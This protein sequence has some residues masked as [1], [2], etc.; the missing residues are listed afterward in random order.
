[1]ECDYIKNAIPGKIPKEAAKDESPE[2]KCKRCNNISTFPPRPITTTEASKRF[3][4]LTKKNA[5]TFQK[6]INTN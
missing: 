6:T 5:E 2:T 1:M 4:A 3:S